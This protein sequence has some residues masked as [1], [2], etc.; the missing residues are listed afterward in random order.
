MFNKGNAGQ[1]TIDIGSLPSGR[2]Y[3]MSF[4]M[5]M[6]FS[7]SIAKSINKHLANYPNHSVVSMVA[8][9]DRGTVVVFEVK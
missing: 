7:D 5:T 2:Q 6:T 3:A 4:N 9:K 8:G 1:K